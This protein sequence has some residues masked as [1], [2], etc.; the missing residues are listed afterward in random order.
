MP[1]A[2][3]LKTYYEGPVIPGALAFGALGAV[4]LTVIINIHTFVENIFFIALCLSLLGVLSASLRS[5]ITKQWIDGVIHLGMFLSCIVIGLIACYVLAFFEMVF[6][7]SEDG[8]ADHLT[9]PTNIEVAEPKSNQSGQARPQTNQHKQGKPSV[10]LWNSFQPGIYDGEI[11]VNPGEAGVL[12]LK[13]FEVTHETALSTLRLKEQSHVRLE[14]S[15]ADPG[16]VFLYNPHFTIYEGD[17]GK[18]YAA[19]IEVWFVPDS[20]SGERKLIEK[21]FK[22]EGWMR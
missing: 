6:G 2:N 13:A 5:F 1:P 21:V 8:F 16:Q 18:P 7:P 14:P 12:Y 4:A 20:G 15:S 10:D 17:W 19:R 22:I 9:I 11:W 3:P